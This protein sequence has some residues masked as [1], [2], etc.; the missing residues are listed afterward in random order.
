[1]APYP[2]CEIRM[3]TYNQ[4]KSWPELVGVLVKEACAVI[5]NWNPNL[6]A[7][8]LSPNEYHIMNYCVNRVWVWGSEP[9]GAGVVIEVS[10]I[11]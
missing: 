11:G 7:I 8:P 2:P 6:K 3:T 5:E 4:S 9:N 1:M 10:R